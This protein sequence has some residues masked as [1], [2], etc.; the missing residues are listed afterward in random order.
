MTQSYFEYL[1]RQEAA[2]FTNEKLDYEKTEPDLTKKV[3]EQIDKNIKDRAQFFQDNIER[4]NKTVAGKTA[5]NLQNLYQLTRTGKEFLDNRQEF[6]E[7]RKAFD[8]LI[9]IYNYPTKREQYATVEKNLQEVEGDL[10]N[11]EDVEI[12]TIE[13]TGTDTTG[14]VVSGTQ[15]LDF[16]KSIASLFGL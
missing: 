2:P 16:K 10:R 15:L 9:A 3:N 1:G 5:R 7:D 12:A 13:Q 14:Q 4:Y 8:E 11:D 6:R